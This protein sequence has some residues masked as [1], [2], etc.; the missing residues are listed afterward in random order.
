[1]QLALG[2]LPKS[3]E[4]GLEEARPLQLEILNYFHSRWKYRCRFI[5]RKGY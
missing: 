3:M 5:H 4:I 2:F 1:M